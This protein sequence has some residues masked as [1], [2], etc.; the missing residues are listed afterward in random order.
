MTR[1][2][3]TKHLGLLARAGLSSALLCLLPGCGGL[4]TY[5]QVMQPGAT[6]QVA[7]VTAQACKGDSDSGG[8]FLATCGI[9]MYTTCPPAWTLED[10]EGKPP[11]VGSHR[12]HD[13]GTEPLPCWK[14]ASTAT[15]AYVNFSLTTVPKI[16]T[17]VTAKLSW[18]PWS[19]H[20]AGQPSN[21]PPHCF[22][23]LFE[24]SAP[25]NMSSGT[26]GNLISDELD[27]P[28]LAKGIATQELRQAIQKWVDTGAP[29]GFFF[30]PS[31]YAESLPGK[32]NANCMTV[33]KS[34]KLEI[35]YLG[36]PQSFP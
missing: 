7:M 4:T 9:N 14:W 29:L 1:F 12:I 25:W 34:L 26:P 17:V 30:A 24:A 2:F 8:S 11:E 20:G 18:D 3:G 32:E 13:P 23:R 33:L 10:L 6:A 35:T 16:V 36:K 19:S 22:K 27:Q 15:R 28:Q 21:Q 31:A 5:H